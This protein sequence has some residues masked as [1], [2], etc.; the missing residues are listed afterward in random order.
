MRQRAAPFALAG[1]SSALA[2]LVWGCGR[3]EPES[4]PEV[5][6]R[7]DRVVVDEQ[8]TPVVVLEE[9]GGTRWLP[10][11]IGSAEAR[12]IAIEMESLHLP[13]PNTH[14]LA[15]DLIHELH[16]EVVRV[17]VTEL[18]D[19]TYYASLHLKSA[20]GVVRIDSRPSDAI[21]IALRADAPIFVREP[22]FSQRE[23]ETGAGSDDA[24]RRE[25]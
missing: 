6:V 22:L 3:A 4:A 2:L 25:I 13:R 18:R 11:W 19:G 15:R 23:Q 8:D 16:A 24:P 21:A 17:V 20:E 5:R 9:E 1:V 12:S 7:V 14:D 10:I